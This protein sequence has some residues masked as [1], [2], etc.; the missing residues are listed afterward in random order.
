M[1][2]KETLQKASARL[3]D[4][5]ELEGLMRMSGRLKNNLASQPSDVLGFDYIVHHERSCFEF[6]AANPPFIGL[7]Q[8][9]PVLCPLGIEIVKEYKLDYKEAINI[10]H[11][12]D[13]GDYFTSL[14]FCKPLV[15]PQATE[16]YWYFMSNLGVPVMIGA[17]SGKVTS[18]N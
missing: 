11:S 7:T 10:F 2:S 18:P 4:N 17:N 1:S 6:Y 15:Y 16:P 13:W 12:G 9:M 8:P 3:G 5:I 14:V